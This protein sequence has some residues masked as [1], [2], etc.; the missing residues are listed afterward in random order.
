MESGGNTQMGSPIRFSVF[1]A[2]L[3][4]VVKIYV[5]VRTQIL[6]CLSFN[7]IEY[8]GPFL[9]GSAERTGVIREVPESPLGPRK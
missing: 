8:T 1:L 5:R 2:R 3:T 4:P 9:T 6:L 7:P